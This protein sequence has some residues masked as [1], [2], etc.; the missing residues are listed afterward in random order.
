MDWDKQH[1]S[2]IIVSRFS[3]HQIPKVYAQLIEKALWLSLY[4]LPVFWRA[5]A[6]PH[7]VLSCMASLCICR[8]ICPGGWAGDA[9]GISNHT[10]AI[11]VA[12]NKHWRKINNSYTVEN[13]LS[14]RKWCEQLHC[15]LFDFAD[16]HYHRCVCL[17]HVTYCILFWNVQVEG[18]FFTLCLNGCDHF[19]QVFVVRLVTLKPTNP[20]GSF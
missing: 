12:W 16:W 18:F 13:E 1:N 19:K 11:W 5:C 14:R 8:F 10:R 2:S 20:Q 9:T 4:S 17:L 3:C 6:I 7:P 15:S